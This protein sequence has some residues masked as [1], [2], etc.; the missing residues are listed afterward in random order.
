M[1]IVDCW[2]FFQSNI[3]Y[4]CKKNNNFATESLRNIAGG[5]TTLILS[6]KTIISGLIF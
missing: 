4:N 6:N 3:L 1:K 5:H 2:M